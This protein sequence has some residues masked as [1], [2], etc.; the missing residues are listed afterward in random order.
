M[1]GLSC[2]IATRHEQYLN[3]ICFGDG[4]YKFQSRVPHKS[5]LPKGKH[6]ILLAVVIIEWC[7]IPGGVITLVEVLWLQYYRNNLN[8]L[9]N[10][11]A[12]LD[13]RQVDLFGKAASTKV[14]SQQNKEIQL[15]CVNG[16]GSALP[17]AVDLDTRCSVVLQR[18][19]SSKTRF[20]G[21]RGEIFSQYTQLL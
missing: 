7:R 12:V 15:H 18:Y 2:V 4:H 9:H 10:L 21:G 20:L 5:G 19:N 16:I 13:I 17:M 8:F 1:L 6:S 14:H 11:Q 3:I